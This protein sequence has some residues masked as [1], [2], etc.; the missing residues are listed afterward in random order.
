MPLHVY[1][2]GNRPERGTP[3]GAVGLP[4]RGKA[5]YREKFHHVS[6]I[7]SRLRNGAGFRSAGIAMGANSTWLDVLG[8]SVKCQES[9]MRS[10]S[11]RGS[12]SKRI[13]AIAAPVVGLIGLLVVTSVPSLAIRLLDVL[14]I[15]SRLSAAVQIG[16][17]EVLP[18][19]S[20][21]VAFDADV[22]VSSPGEVILGRFHRAADG[23][24]RLVT[25]DGASITVITIWNVS[26]GEYY[27]KD[28]KDRWF[29]GPLRMPSNGLRPRQRLKDTVG[30]H[31]YPSRLAFREG[32]NRS[33]SAEDGFEVYFIVGAN[34]SIRFEAPDLNWFPLIHQSVTGRRVERFNVVLRDQAPELFLPPPDA[35]IGY[36]TEPGY[37][38][39]PTEEELSQIPAPPAAP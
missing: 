38:N 28:P 11:V 32:Q 29:R 6:H 26:E 19:P 21:W 36:A 23:S 14:A 27:L 17:R 8:G 5:C 4:R 25:G 33:L 2:S 7:L 31:A 39:E 30:M 34:G 37:V 20:E 12:S 22:M 9:T 10:L 16:P 15:G 35:V 18:S 3:A 24:Q 1:M 13:V